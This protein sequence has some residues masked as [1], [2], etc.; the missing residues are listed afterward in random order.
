MHRELSDEIYK[1]YE[2]RYM[3][4]RRYLQL[5]RVQPQKAGDFYAKYDWLT[6]RLDALTDGK[7]HSQFW[8]QP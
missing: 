6:D 3:A 2:T 4:L 1:I 7:F 5:Q 8:R